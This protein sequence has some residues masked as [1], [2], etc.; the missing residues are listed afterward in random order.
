MESIKIDRTKLL[1]VQNYAKKFGISRPTVYSKIKEKQ[2]DKV[3]IDGVTF[4]RLP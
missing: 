4:I 3:E 2:L 1:T